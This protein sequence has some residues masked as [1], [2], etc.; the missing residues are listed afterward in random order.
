MPTTELAPRAP[1][2]A[3][4]SL[5]DPKELGTMLAAS[6]YFS[7]AR[8]AAQAVVKVLAGAELGFGPIA[9]MT[10]VYIVKGRVTLSAN[11]MAAAIKRHP[12][13]DYRVRDISDTK[14]EVTFMERTPDGWTEAGASE[15]TM[16]DARRA[17]L[18]GGE[19]WKKYPRNMLLWRAMSNGA[20]FFCPDAFAGAPVYTPDEL[21][22][23]V[24]PESG[25]IIEGSFA[26][27]DVPPVAFTKGGAGAPPI[28]TSK[29]IPAPVIAEPADAGASAADAETSTASVAP[30][31]EDEAAVAAEEPVDTTSALEDP[32][33]LVTSEEVA[34][35]TAYLDKL[36]APASFITM[37]RMAH[38]AADLASLS[39][40]QAHEIM[41]LAKVRSESWK[42][43]AT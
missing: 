33:R 29:P 43:P 6:G 24:D 28:Q 7:D 42:A 15:F 22:A 19:N 21:G 30:P 31:A 26:A 40:G 25:E 38:G 1:R 35:L 41:A 16:D 32:N 8:E 34:K 11:L 9:S 3:M 17:G 27:Y 36:N 20:K 12:K 5:E 37:A 10:G 18:A 14:A 39:V 4:G 23:D 13:Y 2:M